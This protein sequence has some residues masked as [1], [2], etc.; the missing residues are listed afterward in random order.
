MASRPGGLGAAG[1]S[2]CTRPGLKAASSFS[3]KPGS[4]PHSLLSPCPPG[5][6]RA[7]GSP[8]VQILPGLLHGSLGG[9]PSHHP[10]CHRVN[11]T[12]APTHLLFSSAGGFTREKL[13]P[14]PGYIRIPKTCPCLFLPCKSPS[15]PPAP[16]QSSHSGPLSPTLSCPS[17]HLGAFSLPLA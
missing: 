6:L 3:G 16:R 11:L 2:E 4:S 17:F 15:T 14:F 1:T 8:S 12:E 13:Y 5:S 7:V 10:F 9:P